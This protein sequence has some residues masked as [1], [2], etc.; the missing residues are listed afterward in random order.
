MSYPALPSPSDI[1]IQAELS[2]AAPRLLR[3][4]ET[5]RRLQSRRTAEYYD[6][7]AWVEVVSVQYRGSSAPTEPSLLAGLAA[8]APVASHDK[9]EQAYLA[10]RTQAQSPPSIL[11]V[12]A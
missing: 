4:H 2:S 6:D 5:S 3:L 8:G 1:A 7:V 11:D 9:R 10:V 12:W